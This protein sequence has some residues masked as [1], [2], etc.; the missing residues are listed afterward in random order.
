MEMVLTGRMMDAEEAERANLVAR[1]VPLPE[2]LDEALKLAE[3]IAEK[4]QPIVAM[5]KEAVNVAYETTLNEGL[6]F[7]RRV[8]YATFA[9]GGPPRGHAGVRGEAHPE[10]QQ[11]LSASRIAAARPVD[12]ACRPALNTPFRPHRELR[13]KPM[14]H[15]RSAKKR[16]RQAVKRTEI[17]RA[18]TSRI[19]T[20]IKKVEL[21]ARER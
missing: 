11:P 9:D 13:G 12:D 7:E 6:R 2:L 18:R 19:R 8:F 15:H 17:N 16:I 1:V 3:T 5:A 10:L 4:S 20:F 14:A 21:G